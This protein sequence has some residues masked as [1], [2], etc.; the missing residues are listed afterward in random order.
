M[1]G[2][3]IGLIA[4]TAFALTAC[5]S[6]SGSAPSLTSAQTSTEAAAEASAAQAGTSGTTAEQAT[7]QS[8]T[9]SGTG[10]DVVPIGDVTDV[11]VLD[12]QC[13]SC[14][15]N[16]VV[17]TDGADGPLVNTI[18]P[19]SGTHF[20]N[21]Y[22]SSLTSQ[23]TITAKGSWSLGIR[24]GSLASSQ[25]SGTGDTALYL[26]Q[27]ATK[28]AITNHGQKNF[29]VH[30]YSGS[31]AVDVAVNEIGSYSGTVPFDLPGL[32]QVESDGSW[33]ITPSP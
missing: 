8:Q 14:T 12:F 31:G 30:V 20:I 22:D 10:D 2:K 19:Y 23:V 16:T 5:S 18:G 7:V 29:V 27:K 6:A 26:R 33:S 4:A 32:V 11:A 24:D 9:F 1:R 15:G 28:A 17:K 25:L 13:P 3:I 21:L